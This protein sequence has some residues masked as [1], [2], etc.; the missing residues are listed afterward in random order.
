MTDSKKLTL[1]LEGSPEEWAEKFRNLRN[2]RSIAT[3]LDVDYKL[4]VYYLYK[5]PDENRYRVFHIRKRRFS[6]STRTISAPAKSLKIIQSKLAQVLASVYIPKATVHGFC[7][8]RSI[9]TNANRHVNQKYVL[10]I[11]L[12]NFFPSINKEI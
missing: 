6:S 9:L 4:L 11:D 10:N 8:G 12:A 5:I 3:L 1:N 7:R 2:P